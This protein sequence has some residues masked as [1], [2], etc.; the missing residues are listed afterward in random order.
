MSYPELSLVLPCF[1]E[2]EN[3]AR[4][5]GESVEAGRRAGGVFEVVV[6]DDGSTDDTVARVEALGSPEVR[7]VR[8][9]ENRGYGAAL[10]T[11]LSTARMRHV[12]Y[13]DGDG[14]LD[15]R[16]LVPQLSRLRDDVVL[17]GY[18]APRRD[19]VLRV[20]TGRAWTALV[21]ATLDVQVRD[22][23]CA[24]KVFPR[25]FLRRAQLQSDG[26][27]IDAELLLEARRLGYR[28]EELPVS[29]RPR[30]HGRA[31]GARPRVI[32]RALVE[33]WALRRRA[34]GPRLVPRVDTGAEVPADTTGHV[35][36]AS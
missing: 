8:H 26:A 11:G 1:N 24:F 16:E 20:W 6:V 17:C 28:I 18:R 14:Q 5:V 3:V 22:V 34:V 31:T 21:G 4:V 23:N 25:A 27:T 29:H 35:R 15:A 13:T 19:P 32:A 2:A 12:F 7:I 10:R 30:A 36:V 9:A 33:L